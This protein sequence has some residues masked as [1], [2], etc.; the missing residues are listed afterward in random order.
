VSGEDVVPNVFEDAPGELIVHLGCEKPFAVMQESLEWHLPDSLTRYRKLRATDAGDG[1]WDGCTRVYL[2]PDVSSPVYFLGLAE[3]VEI[4]ARSVHVDP[5]WTAWVV[6]APYVH[7]A[8]AC[9]TFVVETLDHLGCIE[10]HEHVVVPRALMGMHEDGRVR[11]VIVVVNDVAEVDLRVEL[12]LELSSNAHV[13]VAYHSLA[14]LVLGDLVLG[15]WIVHFVDDDGR[16]GNLLAH[17][18]EI[19]LYGFWDDDLERVV[20]AW[21]LG[22]AVGEAQRNAEV[23]GI[24]SGA[25]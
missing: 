23:E 7:V 10:A 24:N 8:Q 14:A 5:I 3:E 18:L 15:I 11:E 6:V 20:A 25:Q 21:R 19:L 9:N 1:R 13:A 22:A 12:A 4:T 2:L 16:I 17:P